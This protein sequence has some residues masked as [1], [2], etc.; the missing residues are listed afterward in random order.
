MHRHDQPTVATAILPEWI[1]STVDFDRVY[2]DDDARIALAIELAKCNIE[3]ASG[4]PF[5]AAVFDDAG[6]LIALGVNRVEPLQSSLAH[7]EIVALVAAQRKLGRARLNA[8]GR[9]YMLAASAQPCC[10][11]YG[12]VVWAGI[13][14]LLIGARAEDTETLAGFDEGPLPSDWCGELQRR[15]IRVSRDLRREAACAVLAS[16]A[17]RGGT[18]Y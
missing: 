11:C 13:D 7:A 18:L 16:Y 8:D 2:T 14:A 5:G 3:H 1:E 15:G 6:S 4:G 10:Q 9:R 17:A 12:A